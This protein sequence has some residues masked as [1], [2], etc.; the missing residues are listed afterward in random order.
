M[1]MTYNHSCIAFLVY[2]YDLTVFS[3]SYCIFMIMLC[4]LDLTVFLF[5]QTVFLWSWGDVKASNAC[6]HRHIQHANMYS[7]QSH[8][9]PIKMYAYTHYGHIKMYTY[10]NTRIIVNAYCIFLSLGAT[11]ARHQ[12]VFE[13]LTGKNIW[14][15]EARSCLRPHLYE[16][17]Y[18]YMYVWLYV[19][20]IES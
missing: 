3:W 2:F 9:G 15:Y 18:S 7:I 16:C 14:S 12:C 11:I 19:Q 10:T 20:N 5:F 6:I 17:V 1:Y 4:F 8:Y 13:T